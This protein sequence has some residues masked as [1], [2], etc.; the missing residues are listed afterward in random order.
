MPNGAEGQTGGAQ[1]KVLAR[2]GGNGLG[3]LKLAARHGHMD[4]LLS[5]LG[6]GSCDS[7]L[8]C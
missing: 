7:G 2:H 6:M 4:I 1:R 3:A 8:P 5:N